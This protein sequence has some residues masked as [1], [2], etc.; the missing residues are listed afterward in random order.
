MITMCFEL[1]LL[2]YILLVKQEAERSTQTDNLLS[3]LILL[4]VDC[5]IADVVLCLWI[6]V[7]SVDFAFLNLFG[8]TEELQ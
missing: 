8:M 1:K 5:E 6:S 3:S 2:H 7:D 4:H